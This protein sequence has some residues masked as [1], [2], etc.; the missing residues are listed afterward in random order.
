MTCYCFRPK[1]YICSISLVI[2]WL[3]VTAAGSLDDDK[4]SEGDVRHEKAKYYA[5]NN[6]PSNASEKW[7]HFLAERNKALA[8]FVDCENSDLPCKCSIN[9]IAIDLKPWKESG[10]SQVLIENA[11][12]LGILY[13]IIDH[14][15]YRQRDCNFPGRC[16]GIEHFILGIIDQL[17]DSEFVVNVRDWAQIINDLRRYHL[18]GIP[19]PVFSFSKEPAWYKDIMYPAWAFWS[20]GPAIET[21]PTGI[22]N[23]GRTSR[24]IATTGVSWSEKRDIAFFR[25]SRT[26]ADRDP[27]IVLSRNKPDKVDAQYTKNQAWRSPADTLGKEPAPVIRFE[28]QCKYKYLINLRGVAASFRYKH[29]FMCKSVVLNVESDLIEYFYPLLK[30]WVHYVPISSDMKDLEAKIEFL[31][32]NDDVAKEVAE[33]GFELIINHLTM[34]SVSCYWQQLLQEYTKLLNYRP[35]LAEQVIEIKKA[36]ARN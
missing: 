13:Q 21:Y 24:M 18:H 34:D 10:I 28:E 1:F 3:I 2:T 33:K 36:T 7:S 27:L 11:V 22:G 25:G 14:K 9:Q 30:P 15:L 4:H 12:P 32:D 26:S 29:L 35:S 23:W 6:V 20:G 31:R 5:E 8:D 19:L 16:E 17:D